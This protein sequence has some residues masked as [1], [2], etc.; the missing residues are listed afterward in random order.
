[1]VGENMKC[2]SQGTPEY[3]LAISFM[4]LV[5]LII[6]FMMVQKQD[7]SYNFKVFLDAKKVAK[8]VADNKN[9]IA[10]QG[11]GYYRYFSVPE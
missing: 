8:S 3:M 9:T 11:H 6:I 5:F 10:Q 1:M 7:E 2:K 4:L